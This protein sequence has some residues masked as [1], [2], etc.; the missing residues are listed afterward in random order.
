MNG[1][2]S[3]YSMK[4]VQV[5]MYLSLEPLRLYLNFS[6]G[7]MDSTSLTH[8]LNEGGLSDF[9]CLSTS[10]RASSVVNATAFAWRAVNR[11]ST[12]DTPKTAITGQ[13]STVPPHIYGIASKILP[14]NLTSELHDQN[15]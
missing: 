2:F 9:H 12:G 14:Q 8:C 10:L 15:M 5:L 1:M 4:G 13:G 3:T 11:N 6:K 7:I